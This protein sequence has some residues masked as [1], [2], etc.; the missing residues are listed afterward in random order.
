MRSIVRK[1]PTYKAFIYNIQG[2][3]LRGYVTKRSGNSEFKNCPTCDE[4]TLERTSIIIEQPTSTREGKKLIIEKCH[5]CSSYQTKIE[6][7]QENSSDSSSDGS[8][9]DSGGDFGGGSSD[10]GGAGGDW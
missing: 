6:A 1:T 4:L 10:G 8:S 2:I 7:I 9:Y 5:C 3:H